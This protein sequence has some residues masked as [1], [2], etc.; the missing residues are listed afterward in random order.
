M[1]VSG[2]AFLVAR[3]GRLLPALALAA[4][5]AACST[6]GTRVVLLPQAD[7]K[8]S[9]VV[10]STADGAE[11]LS[12]P[13][14]RATAAQ[15][16]KAPPKLDKVDPERLKRDNK[17]LFDLMPPP[18]QRFTVY[19]EAGGTQLTDASKLDM[20]EALSAALARSGG[21][22]VV[23]GYTD[24]IGSLPQNDELSRRR[25]EQVRQIF[26]ARSFPPDRVVAVGRGKREL[27][28]PTPDNVDEPRN[29]RVVI[30]VR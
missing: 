4:T 8:P 23:I 11:T 17:A 19:F 13:F 25:A 14:E 1:T 10:V 7:G 12:T 22:I 6:P 3:C 30:E 18:P 15:G 20:T 26:L 24:S 21:E 9:A 29:R 27:A 2:G 28:V 5:I 16:A